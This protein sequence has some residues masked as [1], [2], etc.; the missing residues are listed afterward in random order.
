MKCRSRKHLSRQFTVNAKAPNTLRLDPT[1]TV[2]LRRH[3]V[4]QLR[5]KFAILKG[6]LM[7][8]VVDED[9]FGLKQVAV[10]NSNPDGCNQYTGP[11]CGKSGQYSKHQVQ[12]AISKV[13]SLPSSKRDISRLGDTDQV[14]V[15]I[16]GLRGTRDANPTN[17]GR[18]PYDAF[19][20]IELDPTKDVIHCSQSTV[21]RQGVIDKLLS[22]EFEREPGILK[23]SNGEYTIVDG[24][25]RAVAEVLATGKIRARVT[26]MKAG[27][28]ARY[29]PREAFKRPTVTNDFNPDQARGPDGRFVGAGSPS[30]VFLPGNSA[31]PHHEVQEHELFHDVQA[32]EL[33]R[34]TVREAIAGFRASVGKRLTDY[35]D[36]A[37]GGRYV[38][39]KLAQFNAALKSR[40]GEKTMGRIV[41]AAAALSWGVT[42]GSSLMGTPIP[43]PSGAVMMAGVALAESHLQLRRGLKAIGVTNAFNADQLRDEHGRWVSDVS[44]DTVAKL[45]NDPDKLFISSSRFTLRDIDISKVSHQTGWQQ[46]GHSKTE[47]PIIVDVD[48]FSKDG[49]QPLDGNHRLAEARSRGE[50]TIRAFVGDLVANEVD[51]S[52]EAERLLRDL[53]MAGHRDDG[54]Y[55]IPIS[56]IRGHDE[57]A[58]PRS[59]AH[60]FDD[61]P[62]LL[63]EP[64]GTLVDGHHRLS[65][66]KA[67]GVRHARVTVGYLPQ[68]KGAPTANR[69]QFSTSPQKLEQFQQW[70]RQQ[71]SDLLTG[72]GDEDLWRRYADAGY[73]K[74]AGRAFDD[75]KRMRAAA[76]A[77]PGRK[78]QADY[79]A[80][81]RDEFL[82]ST[83]AQ[84]VSVERVQM[85]ASRSF[86]DLENVTGDLSARLSRSLGDGLVQGQS[87]RDLAREMAE[88]LDLSQG[89]AET[90]ARTEIIRAHSEGQLDALEK[91]G[92][93][94][95][96]VQ[97]EVLST[98]DGRQCA[99][100]SYLAGTILDIDDARGMIPVHPNCRCCFVP[101]V[102]GL[103]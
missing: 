59:L 102:P 80:G 26:E 58:N 30:S 103:D 11:E 62:P 40:Y 88:D 32:H 63:V 12:S 20:V 94:E 90:I 14:S 67:G 5:K 101:V 56:D 41:K 9:A 44:S 34:P 75:T 81:T 8:L 78:T 92:V 77:P 46:T 68:G 85:L 53:V 1:R 19:D 72:P 38:R 66:L 37:P 83:F 82:R 29:S 31:R 48:A 28:L 35:V 76:P 60:R 87:P 64:D 70:L 23:S 25:H 86:D 33:L 10:V 97:V 74:G 2:T 84:P 89:R 42:I 98:D 7:K 43:V 61:V 54:S 18:A 96:G 15:E 100:C 16:G 21:V 47:G 24:H 45:M 69:F 17:F 93:A 39:E 65:A 3:F 49:A 13:K 55:V 50:K 4:T 95:V 73:R 27:G 22:G 52:A 6:R 91:M 71:Y 36:R 99:E 51:I 57:G 79:D